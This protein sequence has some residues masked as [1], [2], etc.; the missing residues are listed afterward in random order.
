MQQKFTNDDLESALSSALDP[1]DKL[2]LLDSVVHKMDDAEQDMVVTLTRRNTPEGN[3][4][5]LGQ[6]VAQ[7]TLKESQDEHPTQAAEELQRRVDELEE[8]ANAIS[9]ILDFTGAS[10]LGFTE[11]SCIAE[12]VRQRNRALDRVAVLEA[13]NEALRKA[14]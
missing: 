14:R 13:E 1:D 7:L 9:A 2:E 10:S 4:L 12:L 3:F 11:A 5:P 8:N 6:A